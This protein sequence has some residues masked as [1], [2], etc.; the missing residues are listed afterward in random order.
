MIMEV[1]LRAEASTFVICRQVKLVFLVIM[2][3]GVVYCE[4]DAD[5]M[6]TIC[7]QSLVT[8]MLTSD[9]DYLSCLKSAVTS[10]FKP[11]ASTFDNDDYCYRS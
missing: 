9:V 6:L 11:F 7:E 10:L 1:T 8:V 2:M 5:A 3:T 4:F